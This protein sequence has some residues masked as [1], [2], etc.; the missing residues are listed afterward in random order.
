[1]PERRLVLLALASE[2][3]LALLAFIASRQMA[4]D[5]AWGS[6]LRDGILGVTAAL[7]LAAVNYA[8]LTYAPLSWLVRG[9]RA[10]YHEVL[11]PLFGTLHLGSII[12]IGI[13]AGIGE[14]WLFRGVLQSTIG[15]V[16]AAVLFGAAHIGTGSMLPFGVWAALMGAG[17]GGLAIA[18]DG[19]LAPTVAHAVYDMLALVY[20][21][22]DAKQAGS[23]MS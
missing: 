23:A 18:T 10:V 21:R 11:V 1:M 2:G 12:V 15:F 14:E 22:R 9:I 3:A 13:A 6:P 17:L 19:L 8:V 20:I 5:L 4:L 7:G 16:P